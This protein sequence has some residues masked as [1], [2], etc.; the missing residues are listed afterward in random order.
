MYMYSSKYTHRVGDAEGRQ[1]SH[2]DLNFGDTEVG[3][4]LG[5]L[6]HQPQPTQGAGLLLQWQFPWRPFSSGRLSGCGR[7]RFSRTAWCSRH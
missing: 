5:Q 3:V 7:G 2:N 4:A 1:R 6:F